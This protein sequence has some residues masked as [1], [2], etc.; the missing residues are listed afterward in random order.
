MKPRRIL[1]RQ[2]G[3]ERIPRSLRRIA[4]GMRKAVGALALGMGL[5][6]PLWAEP[7]NRLRYLQE[8]FQRRQSGTASGAQ[9]KWVIIAF[10]IG[11]VVIGVAYWLVERFRHHRPYYSRLLLFLEL[12]CVHR[13]SIK[14]IWHLWRWTQQAGIRPAAR[15]FTEPDLW[16]GRVNFIAQAAG[17]GRH[18]TL[19]DKLFAR[20]FG[21]LPA[22]VSPQ[23]KD[24]VQERTDSGR[25]GAHSF[26]SPP[27]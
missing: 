26:G 7:V 22:G 17:L 20:C 14:E 10:I 18:T 11:I 8:E 6:S 2:E 23:S 24:M 5:T 12:C 4:Y 9:L 15:I 21:E 3:L 1:C 27:S 19:W 13:L 25:S 16:E